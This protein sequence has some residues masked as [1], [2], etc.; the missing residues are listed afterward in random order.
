MFAFAI[1]LVRYAPM[2]EKIQAQLQERIEAFAADVTTI[3]Q[4]AVADSVSD[5]LAGT[6]A[7]PAR[8]A[9]AAK[10]GRKAKTKT[11]AKAKAKGKRRAKGAKR[12]PAELVQ[13]EKGLL[14]EVK[15]K[16]GRRIEE[17]AESLGAS[18]K[19]LTLPMKKLIGGKKVKSKGQRR[20]TRYTAR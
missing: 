18:T 20:A 10:V 8:R 14:R 16:G 15:R 13:L 7:K 17:I 3:L 2:N 6:A 5:V 11:K 4:Q 19:D 1:E 9:P 12:S